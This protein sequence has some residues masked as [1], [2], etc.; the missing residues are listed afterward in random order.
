MIV[1]SW[2]CVGSSIQIFGEIKEENGF[3]GKRKYGKRI[4]LFPGGAISSN[5]W[6]IRSETNKNLINLFKFSD[7]LRS[8]FYTSDVTKL[9]PDILLIWQRWMIM[10]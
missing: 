5:V 1:R 8:R 9:M 10:V 2:V 3:Q 7:T 4:S 6:N